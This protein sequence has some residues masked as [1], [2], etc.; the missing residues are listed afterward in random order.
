[1]ENDWTVAHESETKLTNYRIR[2]SAYLKILSS[3]QEDHYHTVE[4]FVFSCFK[5]GFPRLLLLKLSW[6]T[7]IAL[8]ICFLVPRDRTAWSSHLFLERMGSFKQNMNRLQEE[9]AEKFDLADTPIP[10]KVGVLINTSLNPK[11]MP[12]ATDPMDILQLFCAP[13]G[14][15]LDFVL[16]EERLAGDLMRCFLG[17]KPWSARWWQDTRCHRRL[18]I[19]DAGNFN[20]NDLVEETQSFKKHNKI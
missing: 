20:P 9:M 3:E 10:H 14:H 5:I 11:G 16:L 18:T 15:E 8:E 4:C 7:E 17:R 12:I 19:W 13:G 2:R 1:M 6:I